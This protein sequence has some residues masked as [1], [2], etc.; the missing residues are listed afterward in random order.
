LDETITLDHDQTALR[1]V[2]M[3][4]LLKTIIESTILGQQGIF[5][6]KEIIIQ[7]ELLNIAMNQLFAIEQ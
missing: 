4:M 5:V 1:Q 3:S 6:P 7:L 2:I